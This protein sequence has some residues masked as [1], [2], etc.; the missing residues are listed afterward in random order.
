M[1]PAERG[2][3]WGWGA[4]PRTRLRRWRRGSFSFCRSGFEEV[5]QIVVGVQHSN[6]WPARTFFLIFSPHR[7]AEAVI[8]SRNKAHKKFPQGI[9]KKGGAV[10]LLS[11]EKARPFLRP[12]TLR[13]CNQILGGRR[14][15]PVTSHKD[16]HRNSSLPTFCPIYQNYTDTSGQIQYALTSPP[17]SWK[18]VLTFP[19]W[20]WFLWFL[21]SASQRN[22]EK[23]QQAS[24]R[25]AWPR[26]WGGGGMGGDGGGDQSPVS[27]G[28]SDEG[29][30]RFI[31]KS[32]KMW[33][34]IWSQR[35][36]S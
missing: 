12:R 4:D 2:L 11:E 5:P 20:T 35:C 7:A 15:A 3:G 1:W 31:R 16:F 8:W 24:V 10:Y 22:L 33:T 21:R 25:L 19:D 27:A 34:R 14:F 9:K 18:C 13:N 30:M 28:C 23:L 6:N 29:E 26:A 17:S 36:S 32:E